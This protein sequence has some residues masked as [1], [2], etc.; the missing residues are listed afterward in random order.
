[1]AGHTTS[2]L[3]QRVTEALTLTSAKVRLL[4]LLAFA[5]VLIIISVPS[6]V[7]LQMPAN[8]SICH[9]TT[10][11]ALSPAQAS[12]AD[13]ECAGEPADYN[14]RWLWLRHELT[15][16]QQMWQDWSVAIRSTRFETLRVY[17]HFQDGTVAR[18]QVKTGDFGSYWRPNGY[19]AFNTSH[20]TA[21]LVSVTIGLDRLAVYDVLRLRLSTIPQMGLTV[22]L[23]VLLVGIALSLLGASLVF[24]LFLAVVSGYR[25]VLWHVAWL[26][27]MIIWGLVWTQLFLLFLPSL[28]GE[29]TVRLVALLASVAIV[30]A[31]QYM[32]AAFEASVLPRW[33]KIIYYTA[34]GIFLALTLL[35]SFAPLGSAPLIASLFSLSTAV[36]MGLVIIAL[37]I[38]A[39]KNSEASK[40]FALAWVLPVLAVAFSYQNTFAITSD[41]VSEQ[42]LVMIAGAMQTLWLSY[43]TT[44]SFAN[45]RVERDQARARQSELM[46]L[47]ETDPLTRLY[48]RRGLTERFRQELAAV[49]KSEGSVGMMLIDIDHFKSINDTFGHDV[50]DHVLQRIADLLG[51][52][53]QGGGIVA[54]LGGEEFCAVLPGRHGEDLYAAAEQARC[55]LAH[56]DMSMIFGTAERRITASIGV[57]DTRQFPHADAQFLIRMADQALYRAKAEGRNMVVVATA[58]ARAAAD[59]RQR[60]ALKPEDA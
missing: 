57:V 17:F 1:M 33:F 31:S 26:A 45:L 29:A 35:W 3:V 46:I 39:L 21:P 32:L 19:I 18:H 6:R 50:G 16:E 5:L 30:L 58:S 40:D 34:M 43:A 56:A 14:T 10:S 42:L 52:L 60:T 27:C 7:A 24:N 23:T 36:L 49:A 41:V 25:V 54:R 28:A 13:F 44:R 4:W 12:V 47:A 53:R 48:N 22:S 37:I 38:G 8:L 20:P 59:C 15:P 2:L 51:T 9:L 55:L 11:A